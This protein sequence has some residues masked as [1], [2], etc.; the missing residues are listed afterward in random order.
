MIV[1]VYLVIKQFLVIMKSRYRKEAVGFQNITAHNVREKHAKVIGRSERGG[2]WNGADRCYAGL[3]CK[4][5][6]VPTTDR[7]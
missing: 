3:Y 4:D 1:F 2:S 5:A 6:L 7:C